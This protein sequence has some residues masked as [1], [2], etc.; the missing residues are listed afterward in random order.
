MKRIREEERESKAER[1]QGTWTEASATQLLT[2][3]PPPLRFQLNSTRQLTTTARWV[4]RKPE[5]QP[6]AI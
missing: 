3:S 4:R 6:R 5:L 2:P 1:R